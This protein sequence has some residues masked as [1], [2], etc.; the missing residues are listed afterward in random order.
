MSYFSI[1]VD[2]VH[3]YLF[4]K[5]G[6]RIFNKSFHSL[7]C[8]S[9]LLIAVRGRPATNI[10]VNYSE[11]NLT[12]C[13][14]SVSLL[15]FN[16]SVHSDEIG[17]IFS[18]NFCWW[19]WRCH[20][21]VFF[22]VRGQ[23]LRILWWFLIVS[24]C[25]ILFLLLAQAHNVNIKK[26]KNK[27]L[28]LQIA[29]VTPLS[30]KHLKEREWKGSKDSHKRWHQAL[31]GSCARWI[32]AVCHHAWSEKRRR[33]RGGG[34]NKKK[35]RCADRG[36]DKKGFSGLLTCFSLLRPSLPNPP[37]MPAEQCPALLFKIS[38]Q[39]TGMSFLSFPSLSPF[40]FFF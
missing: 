18:T 6:T 24:E 29:P 32:R 40:F 7:T 27:S 5:N 31:S 1:N 25:L 16:R 10:Q 33:R 11:T 3:Q 12:L 17:N 20:F 4:L 8:F 13:I 15:S 2:Q 26:N 28:L 23:S 21:N 36:R 30:Y 9:I 37:S 39:M 34:K 19:R 22:Y 14:C 35:K 38:T